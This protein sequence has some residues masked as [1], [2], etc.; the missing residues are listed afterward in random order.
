MLKATA[1]W[2][3]TPSPQDCDRRE[4]RQHHGTLCV[5]LLVSILFFLLVLGKH[6][7]GLSLGIGLQMGAK[8]LLCCIPVAQDGRANVLLGWVLEETLQRQEMGTSCRVETCQ[9]NGSMVRLAPDLLCRK[10]Q[11][12]Y[13]DTATTSQMGCPHIASVDKLLAYKFRTC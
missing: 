1:Q 13:C 12:G 8:L 5:S 2:Q 11:A 6:R 7:L 4:G 9:L 10:L 3:P